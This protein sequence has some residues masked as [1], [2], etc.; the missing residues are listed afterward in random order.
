MAQVLYF[1]SFVIMISFIV[2]NLF[3]AVVTSNMTTASEVRPCFQ[4]TTTNSVLPAACVL[5]LKLVVLEPGINPANAKNMKKC[6]QSLPLCGSCR[7]MQ[8]SP[9]SMPKPDLNLAFI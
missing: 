6:N 9:N 8:S 5:S 1:L 2:L 4:F 3:I 7:K